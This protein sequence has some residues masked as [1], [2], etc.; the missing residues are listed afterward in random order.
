MQRLSLLLLLLAH[1]GYAM[2]QD[3]PADYIKQEYAE[4]ARSQISLEAVV[5]HDFLTENLDNTEQVP[6]EWKTKPLIEALKKYKVNPAILLELEDRRLAASHSY[7]EYLKKEKKWVEL[8][9]AKGI[10]KSN[11]DNT[12]IFSKRVTADDP[13]I[14]LDLRDRNC[15][16]SIQVGQENTK[17]KEY[18]TFKLVRNTHKKYKENE[19]EYSLIHLLLQCKRPEIV[20]Q[21]LQAAAEYEPILWDIATMQQQCD[22][23]KRSGNNYWDWRTVEDMLQ[24][25][26]HRN[27]GIQG[28]IK[29]KDNV[30]YISPLIFATYFMKDRIRKN[31]VGIKEAILHPATSEVYFTLRPKLMKDGN[32]HPYVDYY[33]DFTNLSIWY[34]PEDHRKRTR[35]SSLRY[36][37]PALAYL[38]AQEKWCGVVDNFD[39]K[40][41]IDS[42]I[43]KFLSK[44]SYWPVVN[45][46]LAGSRT[47]QDL[48]GSISSFGSALVEMVMP[49]QKKQLPDKQDAKAAGHKK[50]SNASCIIV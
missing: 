49:N 47:C 46:I 15:I 32:G 35:I 12:I 5:L 41:H 4:D 24:D 26:E 40:L 29:G 28:I 34:G 1:H 31:I 38:T 43:T 2:E 44:K 37:T 19:R 22:E 16:E 50:K 42:H 30:L 48:L 14:Y 21:L 36:L 8:H 13:Y 9:F 27:R 10:K 7:R 6:Q 17:K 20:Q 39:D 25:A 11:K 33:K 18:E 3:Y 23:G 45:I